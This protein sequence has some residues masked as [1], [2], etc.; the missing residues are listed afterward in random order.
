MDFKQVNGMGKFI[1]ELIMQSPFKRIPYSVYIG[2][3]LYHPVHG[4]YMKKG[5]K[6]GKEGD[7]ITTPHAFP[8]FAKALAR[9]F[10]KAVNEGKLPP[11][12]C[13]IGGGDGRFAKFVLKE[14]ETFSPE[15]FANIV[16]YIVEKSSFH[17]RLQYHELQEYS[18]LRYFSSLQELTSAIGAFEGLL[19]SNEWFDALPVEV[20]QQAEDQL[21]E[22]WVSVDGADELVEVL[23]PLENERIR[24][25]LEDYNIQLTNNQRMEIPLAMV[26]KLEE[27]HSFFQRGMMVTVDYGYTFQEL[28][29]PWR[30]QGSLRGYFQHQLV[31]NPLDHA[32]QMDLTTH[33]HFDSF[34]EKGKQYGAEVAVFARQHEFLLSIGIL[35]LLQENAD[36]NPFSEGSKQNRAIRNLM[37]DDGM[38]NHFQV[39]VQEKGVKLE[40]EKLFSNPFVLNK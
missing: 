11:A 15:T 40:K 29:H 31:S 23:V 5:V 14:W 2:T 3:A 36:P 35:D 4:Y 7:F 22:V 26:E 16:Y 20:I 19:F 12:I 8:V 6:V 34:I 17:Q 37:I 39:I 33:I 21:Y 28:R 25:Y 24:G 30:Q 27:I 18:Q 9:F 38:S 13:E 10:C 32:G 1:K